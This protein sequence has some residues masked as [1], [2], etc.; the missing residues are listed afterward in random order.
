MRD[1]VVDNFEFSIISS[2]WNTI[3]ARQRWIPS[4]KL[5]LFLYRAN[6]ESFG[7]QIYSSYMSRKRITFFSILFSLWFL[8]PTSERN[9]F[10]LSTEIADTIWKGADSGRVGGELFVPKMRVLLFSFCPSKRQHIS[11]ISSRVNWFFVVGPHDLGPHH[12]GKNK[13]D[14][15]TD[16][17]LG[18]N[19][20]TL[21][22]RR[23]M[24]CEG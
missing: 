19:A 6:L 22:L 5:Q 24:S 1:L 20:Q 23:K 7:L 15:S 16:S 12:M 10:N 3:S 18:A 14:A 8:E 11:S 21:V 4:I 9:E 13:K 2:I 17:G